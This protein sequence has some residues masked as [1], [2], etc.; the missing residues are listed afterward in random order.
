MSEAVIG[1]P[2]P[3]STFTQSDGSRV[4]YRVF[5]SQEVYDCKQERIYRSPA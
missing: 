1:L 5:S 4:L 2:R 3:R